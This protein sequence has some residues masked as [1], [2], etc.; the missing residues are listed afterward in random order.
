MRG[1]RLLR[2]LSITIKL[3]T[4]ETL[5]ADLDSLRQ[6]GVGARAG[7]NRF[8]PAIQPDANDA[9]SGRSAASNGAGTRS[10]R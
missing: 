9:S 5:A 6:C 3:A 10:D 2:H 4:R 7:R 1:A 8:G